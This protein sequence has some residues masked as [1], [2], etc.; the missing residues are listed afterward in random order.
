[1]PLT[2]AGLWEKWKDGMLSFTILIKVIEA[3]DE[4]QYTYALPEK[5]GFKDMAISGG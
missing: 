1:L 4:I 2:F 3:I 5:I